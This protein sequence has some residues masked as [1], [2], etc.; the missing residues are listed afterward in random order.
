MTV[1]SWCVQSF[2]VSRVRHLAACALLALALP[3]SASAAE[4]PIEVGTELMATSNVQLH[5]AEI[6]KGSRVSVTKVMK[7]GDSVQT[8]NVA[9]ADGHVVKISIAQVHSYFQV[10]AD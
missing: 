2:A 4:H 1:E 7:N 5:S 9:L 3:L 6:A 8:V 10:V